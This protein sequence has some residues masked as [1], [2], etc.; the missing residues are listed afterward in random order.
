MFAAK[1]EMAVRIDRCA[2]RRRRARIARAVLACSRR[3]LQRANRDGNRDPTEMETEIKVRNCAQGQGARRI[4]VVW[5]WRGVRRRASRRR[6][7]SAEN[8]DGSEK[9]NEM[10][11][12]YT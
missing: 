6:A 11:V 7:N 3:G 8:R 5:F 4:C 1:T 9:K 12:V 2:A 10:V